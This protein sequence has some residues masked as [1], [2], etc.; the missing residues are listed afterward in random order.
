MTPDSNSIVDLSAIP[1][2]Q[3]RAYMAQLRARQMA[4]VQQAEENKTLVRPVISRPPM[5]GMMQPAGCFFDETQIT[6]VPVVVSDEARAALLKAHHEARIFPQALEEAMGWHAAPH[7]GRVEVTLEQHPVHGE[8][9]IITMI[10][11]RELAG[12]QDAPPRHV[13]RMSMPDIALLH[14]Y[15]GIE[16]GHVPPTPARASGEPA[17]HAA[18]AAADIAKQYPYRFLETEE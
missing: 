8:R 7:V 3:R 5:F 9:L 15:N 2:R 18:I 10:H 16:H 17:F 14:G 12:R 4:A 1:P 6:R 13:H 11:T